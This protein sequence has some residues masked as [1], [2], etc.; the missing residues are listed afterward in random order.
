MNEDYEYDRRLKGI[1]SEQNP[2]AVDA[3]SALCTAICGAVEDRFGYDEIITGKAA[4]PNS[5][6]VAFYVGCCEG[7]ARVNGFDS[8]MGMFCD[9]RFLAA[10]YCEVGLQTRADLV[11]ESLALFPPEDR[12]EGYHYPF[13]D[14]HSF[15]Q[16]LEARPHLGQAVERL[17]DRF[18]ELPE[19]GVDQALAS[20]IRA[21]AADFAG[22][23]VVV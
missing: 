18:F 20:Y 5:W 13:M 16:Y 15:R 21:R 22:L 3:D 14:G 11:A 2:L 17:N 12:A 6:K 1:L 9:H 7:F 8:L 4:M 19:K 23:D 10:S